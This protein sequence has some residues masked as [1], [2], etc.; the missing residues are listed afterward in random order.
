MKP[1]RANNLHDG[2]EQPAHLSLTAGRYES[3]FKD[4]NIIEKLGGIR[5]TFRALF[6]MCGVVTGDGKR[7]P[8][9]HNLN[10]LP[11]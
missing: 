4:G 11:E 7:K 1:K 8:D 5:I 9:Q 2:I 3:V 6:K 10:P